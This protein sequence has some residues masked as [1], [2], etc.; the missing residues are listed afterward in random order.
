M[1]APSDTASAS[2]A[3]R[4]EQTDLY[5]TILEVV[6]RHRGQARITRISYGAGMPVDRLRVSIDRLAALGLLRS[7][8]DEGRT[9]YDVTPRG[10][11]F[12][13]LYWRMRAYTEMLDPAPVVLR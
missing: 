3:R 6:K 11:E 9:V 8:T 2:G 1:G 12:L 7:R 4:R 10:Q 13:T 5:A